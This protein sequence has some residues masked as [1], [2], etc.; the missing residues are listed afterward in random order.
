MNLFERLLWASENLEPVQTK[1][2]IIYEDP[3]FPD[4]PA[5]VVVASGEWLA[6]ALYGGLLPPVESY[7]NMTLELVT[8]TG[9][10]ITCNYLEAQQH[11][12]EKKIVSEKVLND[13]CNTDEPLGPMTEEEAIEYLLMKDVPTR[14]WSSDYKYNRTMFKICT[15]EQLPQTRNYRNAWRLAA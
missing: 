6:C 2:R 10:K 13:P 8:D 3:S 9:E 15:T 1:Y 14:V 4:E 5:K 7:H 12:L 11:R